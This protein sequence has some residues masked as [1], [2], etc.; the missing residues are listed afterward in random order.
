MLL[1]ENVSK[2]YAVEA[3]VVEALHDVDA[4][5]PRAAVTALVGVSGSGKSTLLRLLAGL[6]APTRGRVVAD[7]VDLTAASAAAHS[8]FSPH[9]GVVRLPACSRQPLP[10]PDASPSTFPRDAAGGSS[11]SGSR[12]AGTAR[13]SQLSGGELARASLAVAL[14]RNT[15]IVVV[16]EPT[17]ELDH[18]SAR[19]LLDAL[20]DAASARHDDRGRHARP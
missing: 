13:A 1:V 5:I 7:G 11:G 8:R 18:E 4:E 20:T 3:G 15:P 12:T 6:E 16:D 19:A 14:A 9:A 17:A 10:A 2:R